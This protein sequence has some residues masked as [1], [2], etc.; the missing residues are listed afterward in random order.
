MCLNMNGLDT[1]ICMV[2]IIVNFE[3]LEIAN[4]CLGLYLMWFSAQFHRY[5][6]LGGGLP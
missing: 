6:Q 5:V 1:R 3:L 2:A 4:V